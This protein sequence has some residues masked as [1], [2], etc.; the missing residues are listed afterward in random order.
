[1]DQC[2]R[3]MACESGVAKSQRTQEYLKRR[4][5]KFSPRAPGQHARI[6]ERRGALLRDTNHRI[7]AQLKHGGINVP[8]NIRLGEAT[9]AGNAMLTINDSTPYNAVYGRVPRLL[10]S[11]N[12]LGSEISE[13]SNMPGLIRDTHRLREVSVPC[14]IEGAAKARLDRALNAR[15]LPAGER[16]H[17]SVGEEVDYYLPP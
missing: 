2:A 6:I 5:I 17:Y 15:A 1:M 10:P 7:D 4:G 9:F 16:E 8:Y 12:S 13:S 3:V 14:M 11:I